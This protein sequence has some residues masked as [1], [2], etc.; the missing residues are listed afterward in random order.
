[1]FGVG[2]MAEDAFHV[3]TFTLEMGDDLLDVLLV[4]TADHD[5][6]SLLSQATGN[7]QTNAVRGARLLEEK[8]ETHPLVDAVTTATLPSRRRALTVIL[9]LVHREVSSV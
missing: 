8:R 1:M 2:H 5:G 9:L 6:C 3:E 4:S 7:R